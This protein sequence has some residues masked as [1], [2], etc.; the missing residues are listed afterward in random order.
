MGLAAPELPVAAPAPV[1]SAA[2]VLSK[3]YTDS[4][5]QIRPPQGAPI[6]QTFSAN[7]TLKAVHAHLAT[8]GFPVGTYQLATTFPRCDW[9]FII[10][11]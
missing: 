4:R 5:L 6:T 1:P 8:Q 3:D 11:S 10:E 7:D 2:P 9:S